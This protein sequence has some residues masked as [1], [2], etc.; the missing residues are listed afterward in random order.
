MNRS[1]IIKIRYVDL[2]DLS[3]EELKE[4]EGKVI[5]MREIAEEKEKLQNEI[6]YPEMIGI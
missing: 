4:L 2:S 6:E 5:F 3:V 1:E